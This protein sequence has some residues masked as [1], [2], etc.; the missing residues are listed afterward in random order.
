LIWNKRDEDDPVQALLAELTEPPERATPRGWQLDVPGM[1]AASGLF[2]PVSLSEFR[3]VQP[4]DASTLLSRL[5]SSS[6]VA[7]LPKNRRRAL[8]Q[9][10]RAALDHAAP[11]D[12]IAYTTVV[13]TARRV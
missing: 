3:H 4:T 10:L 2:G 1:V 11:V 12:N 5:R 8:E 7:G 9:R 6:F 13:Y